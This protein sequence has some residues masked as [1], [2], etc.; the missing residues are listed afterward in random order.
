MGG[1]LVEINLCQLCHEHIFED[2]NTVTTNFYRHSHC[3]ISEYSV[4]Q[5]SWDRLVK[6]N[7]TYM[8][9]N[10]NSSLE[11]RL[12]RLTTNERLCTTD[13]AAS[14]NLVTQILKQPAKTLQIPAGMN[15]L[16]A[17]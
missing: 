8:C 14:V 11:S 9:M 7:N 10:L 13:G 1:W 15:K 17:D 6:S 12:K 16:D 2:I 3:D 4:Y 5:K